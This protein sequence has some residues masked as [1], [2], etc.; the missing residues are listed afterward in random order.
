MPEQYHGSDIT[1]CPVTSGSIVD[2]W[3]DKREPRL[4]NTFIN[5]GVNQMDL[6]QRKLYKRSHSWAHRTS[7]HI[8]RE[9]TEKRGPA[10]CLQKAWPFTPDEPNENQL[11][12]HELEIGDLPKSKAPS[13]GEE[14]HTERCKEPS[15]RKFVSSP[16]RLD[17]EAE[18]S[19]MKTDYFSDILANDAHASG[20]D[21]PS[22]KTKCVLSLSDAIRHSVLP[23]S[24][25]LNASLPECN[26]PE[27]QS[28]Q[29][30]PACAGTKNPF[31][32]PSFEDFLRDLQR[33]EPERVPDS[34]GYYKRTPQERLQELLSWDD[35]SEPPEC[36]YKPSSSN[37]SLPYSPS[38][39][40]QP[41][42]GSDNLSHPGQPQAWARQLQPQ[43]PQCVAL[44][45]KPAN[46]FAAG[47]YHVK[48][49]ARAPSQTPHLATPA[50]QPTKGIEFCCVQQNATGLCHVQRETSMPSEIL[51]SAA[52]AGHPVSMAARHCC[53]KQE[54]QVLESS[55]SWADV[56]DQELEAADVIVD[57]EVDDKFKDVIGNEIFDTKCQRKCTVL[58]K[59]TKEVLD[60]FP[61]IPEGC[62]LMIRN[63]PERCT[64]D[65]LV[66]S[67]DA[68]EMGSKLQCV[69]LPAIFTN[70]RRKNQ[71]YAFVNFDSQSAADEIRRMWHG[72]YIF[73]VSPSKCKSGPCRYLNIG[74][75]KVRGLRE[76]LLAWSTSKTSRIKNA[77]F[78]PHL[79]N[80]AMPFGSAV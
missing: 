58:A 79:F 28:G 30:W 21:A 32:Y 25:A 65:E 11:I 42:A 6:D 19:P 27:Q 17:C 57:N 61:D 55:L 24:L 2:S 9:P 69:Y 60:S 1:P 35:P 31:D 56:Y 80:D 43:L 67:I 34:P 39:T 48:Q 64:L 62:T 16:P 8:L 26:I 20:D 53:A 29:V 76:N 50:R 68:Y 15:L 23:E 18:Q 78:R 66:T 72:K 45:A 75:P 52:V 41:S 71:G 36:T 46:T 49:D 13:L 22:P 4:W 63:I 3:G 44:A 73:D 5:L 7:K 14:G 54:P 77:A 40:G 51:P 10:Q 38:A 74:E 37:Q 70:G 12:A 59:I 47:P 33:R